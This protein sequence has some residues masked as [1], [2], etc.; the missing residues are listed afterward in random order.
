MLCFSEQGLYFFLG[1]SDKDA[2]LPF[3]KWVAGDIILSI[4]KKGYYAVPQIQD[5][6]DALFNT[7]A[8][9]LPFPMTKEAVQERADQLAAER[10]RE[11]EKRGIV[12]YSWNK[13]VTQFVCPFY[14]RSD[15][16]S[17]L[18]DLHGLLGKLEGI[19]AGLHRY[20]LQAETPEV[21]P[22]TVAD[23][24]TGGQYPINLPLARF[25]AE[26]L[27]FTLKDTDI[28]PVYVAYQVYLAYAAHPL[29][30]GE[31]GL[32]IADRYPDITVT[33]RKADGM[34]QDILKRCRFR[35]TYGA[36]KAK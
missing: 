22:E 4:R 1:R 35:V 2:A 10:E 25:V 9:R 11:L 14:G 30:E 27:D 5:R 18:T 34:A 31:F 13:P 26:N 12:N 23:R 33:K 3:Q 7:L 36:F 21:I 19:K 32:Y 15:V 17:E 28:I 16:V 20:V 6:L 24:V 8:E 29:G